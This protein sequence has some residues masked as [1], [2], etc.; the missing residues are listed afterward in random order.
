MKILISDAFDPSLPGKLE[1]FGEVTDDKSALPEADIVL[2]R[3]KTK[4]TADYIDE[5]KN[6]KMII[7]GGVGLDNIDLTYA[8][9]KGIVVHNTAAA[10]SIAVAEEAMALMLAM[11]NHLIRAHETMKQGLWAKKE[12]KRTELYRKTL[13]LLGAGRIATEV[14]KRAAAFGMKILAYDPYVKSHEL[15]EMTG[16]LDELLAAAD[17]ISIHTPLTDE[18]KG[19]INAGAIAKMKDGVRL[20]NTGRAKVVIEQDLRDALESGKVAGYATDVWY[21]DPPESSPL[22]DAPNVV[23]A[24]HIGASTKENLLRI[25]DIIE[26]LIEE[27]TSQ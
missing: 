11:P 25:G 5:A 27:F 8:K 23:L 24:P 9:E 12:L 6:L 4:C 7:R 3:S 16:S 20:V 15:A 26:E 22:I 17:Y 14:A 18:T 2:V 10:S 13:G 1:R 21:S 19:M